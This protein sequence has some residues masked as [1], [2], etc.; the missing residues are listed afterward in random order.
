MFFDKMKAI[1]NILDILTQNE[2]CDIEI[3][4][5][6]E[7]EEVV[8][9]GLDDD[10]FDNETADIPVTTKQAYLYTVQHVFIYRYRS[11]RMSPSCG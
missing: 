1:F 4:V 3:T 6:T 9:I 10:E 8:R 7:N 11:F 2:F 5:E